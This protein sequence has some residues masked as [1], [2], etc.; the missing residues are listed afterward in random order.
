MRSFHYT[1]E[2]AAFTLLLFLHAWLL[3]RTLPPGWA[4]RIFGAL[5]L[6]GAL[7]AIIVSPAVWGAA[8]EGEGQY[9]RAAA[10]L[11]SL[12][13]PFTLGLWLLSRRAFPPHQPARRAAMRSLALLPAAGAIHGI[14]TGR[15]QFQVRHQ[16]IC[17]PNLPEALQGLRMVQLSDIH[18]G[19]FLSAAELKRVVGM[20]NELDGDLLF[21]TGDLITRTDDLLPECLAILKNLRAAS[22]I[23]G[24]MGNHE[25]YA[26]CEDALEQQASRFGWKFLRHSRQTIQLPGARLNIA[27]VDYEWKKKDY[28]SRAA[29]LIEPGA[30]NLLLAHNPDVFPRA[31]E[32]GF[33]LTLS[34]HTHGGQVDVELLDQHLNVVRVFTP[35]TRGL[36]NM[37]NSQCFVNSGVGAIG[38]PLRIGAPPEVALIELCA[39]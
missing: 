36:Y 11:W 10:L 1:Y 25:A 2:L 39:S 14:K 12:F 19:P 7:T 9:L 29:G 33:Q 3:R 20:A 13:A 32:L 4:G 38:V 22:P 26:A 28:L 30:F 5:S 18:Y 15:S 31:A 16:K 34:G 23:L 35:Y 21:I 8:A 37:G 27:G 24:C 6:L 17:F